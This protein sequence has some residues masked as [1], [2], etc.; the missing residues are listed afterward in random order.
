MYVRYPAYHVCWN[1]Y[2]CSWAI[3]LIAWINYL[4]TYLLYPITLQHKYYSLLF[5]QPVLSALFLYSGLQIHDVVP[6]PLRSGW[7]EEW[8]KQSVSLSQFSATPVFKKSTN[9]LNSARP[10]LQCRIY[11]S[12]YLPIYV[13]MYVFM[14]RTEQNRTLLWFKHTQLIIILKKWK[15]SS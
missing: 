14:N 12:M 11:L 5:T 4:L 7:H 10:C 1:L 6:D 13:C 9:H 8:R 15:H 3:W 2:M